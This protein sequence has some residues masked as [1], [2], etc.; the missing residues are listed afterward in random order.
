MYGEEK[1]PEDSEAP[2]PLEYHEQV[3]AFT[4]DLWRLTTRY[5]LEFD[6]LKE[7]MV[8]VLFALIQEMSVPEVWDLGEEMFGEDDFKD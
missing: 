3:D 6:L 7:S 5:R 4:E 2:P 8:G 1:E